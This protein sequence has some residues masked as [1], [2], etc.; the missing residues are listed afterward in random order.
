LIL[1]VVASFGQLSAAGAD[2]PVP[3]ELVIQ[4]FRVA[5]GGDALL[6]P[7]RLGGKDHLC[8][9]DTG[10][11]CTA[12]D[13]SLPLG[14]VRWLDSA[15]AIDGRTTQVTV[16]DAPDASVGALPLRIPVVLSQDMARF[17]EVWGQPIEGILGM[18]FLGRHVLRIDCN[19]GELLFLRAA[20]KGAGTAVPIHWQPGDSPRV[21][22]AIGNAEPCRFVID[23]GYTG[24][25]S[26]TLATFRVRDLLLNGE[27]SELGSARGESAVGGHTT[28]VFQG[29]RLTLGGHVVEGPIF[30]GSPSFSV[31]GL[32]FWSRFVVTFDFPKGTAYL[33]EG[34][35]YGRADLW[36]AS[37]LR[38]LL[39]AGSVVVGSVDEGSPGARAGLK[40]GDEVTKLGAVRTDKASLFELK[41]E[42]CRRVRLPCA[43]R[44]GGE[45]LRVT[46]DLT[47]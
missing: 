3:P 32:G 6:L 27:L 11:A 41:G 44:R 13:S 16:H 42:L 45:V 22:A 35:S 2:V 38:L 1:S 33:A 21:R 12:F 4:R 34:R 29:S 5:T 25:G 10:S 18:D 23:T 47:E 39:R 24:H 28:R 43:V 9:D 19:R 20:P 8:S 14:A 30:R 15:L 37:G 40:E 7:V 36:N 31:L 17:R 26:G 46:I